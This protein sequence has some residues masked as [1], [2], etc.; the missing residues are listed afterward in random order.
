MTVK[1]PGN[2]AAFVL[3]HAGGMM[4]GYTSFSIMDYNND[5]KLLAYVYQSEECMKWNEFWEKL[6]LVM[7]K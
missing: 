2:N 1:L 3:Y 7:K 5:P 6:K 4:A